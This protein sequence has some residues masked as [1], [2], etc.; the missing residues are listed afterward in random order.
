MKLNWSL[1][2]LISLLLI[3]GGVII[4]SSNYYSQENSEYTGP[5]LFLHFNPA[6]QPWPCSKPIPS[7]N[8]NNTETEVGP[9]R[10]Y[11][12]I[13]RK[14]NPSGGWDSMSGWYECET[15]EY[16]NETWQD[17]F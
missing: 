13:P 8:A 5:P 15:P 1:L 3:G 10:T 14:Q 6:S 17:S 2:I 4:Y 12:T 16:Y 9:R 7:K 11:W